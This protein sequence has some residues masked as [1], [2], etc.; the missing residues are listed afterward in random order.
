MVKKVNCGKPQKS[1]TQDILLFYKQIKGGKQEDSISRPSE[2]MGLNK[3]G[4]QTSSGGTECLSFLA[5]LALM[6]FFHK[7]CLPVKQSTFIVIARC[8]CEY[9]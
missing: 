2:T 6:M 8:Y 1:F 4:F 5:R 7:D 3:D 9:V